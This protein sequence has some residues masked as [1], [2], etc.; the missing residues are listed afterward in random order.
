MKL[1]RLLIV[2]VGAAALV[3]CSEE[4]DFLSKED[5]NPRGTVFRAYTDSPSETK[6]QLSEND[7]TDVWWS[8]TESITVFDG[9]GVNNKF[10]SSNSGPVQ[11]ADFVL[12]DNT[13]LISEPDPGDYY[14]ALYP[15]D[16][17]ATLDGGIIHTTYP[18]SFEVTRYGSFEDK[19]NLSVARSSSFNLSF[20]NLLG[21][22]RLGITGDEGITK[23]VFRGNSGE[24]L[25]GNV[26]IDVANLTVSVD[27][28]GSSDQLVMTGNFATSD[29][30]DNGCYYYIP[31]ATLSFPEGFTLVFYKDDGTTYT[32]TKTT[33]VDF[34][35]GKRRRLWVD[36]STLQ[37]QYTYTRV[38]A[39]SGASLPS[40]NDGDEYIV[41]YPV[42]DGTYKVFSPQKLLN[43][44]ENFKSYDLSDFAFNISNY[45]YN[46]VGRDIF[47]NDF[48]TVTG[49][50]QFITVDPGTGVQVN[51]GTATL[52]NETASFP[53]SHAK[54]TGIEVSINGIYVDQWNSD[55]SLATGTLDS[56]DMYVL[57][58]Q[59]LSRHPSYFS[60]TDW[61]WSFAIGSTDNDLRRLVANQYNNDY[62]ITAGFITGSATI[63]GKT[64]NYEGFAFK[65]RFLFN[66]TTA[67]QTVY[68]YR[69][70]PSN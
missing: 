44:I 58:D 52:E 25:A 9:D 1:S 33:S 26:A 36:L 12:E 13:I 57:C 46:I 47:N 69:R 55:C 27:E 45:R 37:K 15:Y 7:G 28:T 2:L 5:S 68:I 23:I 30:M 8:A 53:K 70:T 18:A 48:I 54:T 22:I 38:E 61:R 60:T 63:N 16:S 4:F 56:E 65:D 51:S 14:Y 34:N 59:I 17:Q 29:E 49:N 31:L 41:A 35:R 66:P 67:L 40:F 21:W 6:T 64:T 19:M 24:K 20:K 42:G 3:S 11:S 10:V 50:D 62:S 43:N 32:Y 39:P